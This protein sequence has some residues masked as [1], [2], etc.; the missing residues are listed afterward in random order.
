MLK[1]KKLD[2]DVGIGNNDIWI[3]YNVDSLNL[4]MSVLSNPFYTKNRPYR[5]KD[6]DEYRVWLFKEIQ[7]RNQ[8]YFRLKILMNKHVDEYALEKGIKVINEEEYFL[9]DF[10]DDRHGLVLIS[11]TEWLIDQEIRAIKSRE[12]QNA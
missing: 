7:K 5:E 4:G 10:W 6:R 3:G 12:M 9:V 2:T 1:T 11:A 8:I